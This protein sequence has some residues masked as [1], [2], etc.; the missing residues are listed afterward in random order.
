[1]ALILV[2][3][4]LPPSGEEPVFEW[5]NKVEHFIAYFIMAALFIYAFD[6]G[7][8]SAP[9]TMLLVAAFL[10]CFLYGVIIE[11]LQ[12]YL[13]EERHASIADALFNGLGALSYVV[14]IKLLR[15]RYA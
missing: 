6:P 10:S 11:V 1:M 5:L 13:S 9:S 15:R 2:L 4:L 7:K 12:G 8:Q 14:L 3:C